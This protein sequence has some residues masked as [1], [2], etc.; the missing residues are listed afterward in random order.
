MHLD[1]YHYILLEIIATSNNGNPIGSPTIDRIFYDKRLKEGYS[2]DK[3]YDVKWMPLSSEL[4]QLGLI[5][6][7]GLSNKITP[8]GREFLESYKKDHPA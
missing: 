3:L 5:E 8:K 2:L 1:H 7:Q 6:K 4:A